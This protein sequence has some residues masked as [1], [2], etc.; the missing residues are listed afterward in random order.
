MNPP[1]A[2]FSRVPT[3][4]EERYRL[5]TET[6]CWVGRTRRS[7]SPPSMKWRQV[8][9]KGPP[10]AQ[11]RV[12]FKSHK[13]TKKNVS[14]LTIKRPTSGTSVNCSRTVNKAQPRAQVLIVHARWT[15][16]TSGS[17][18]NYSSLNKQRSQ[19]QT[20]QTFCFFFLFCFDMF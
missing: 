15:K 3:L 8:K 5:Q 18:G 12:R 19:L 7:V 20:L 13:L 10:R 6:H 16:P 4:V 17:S 9:D 2:Q 1:I 11:R 14:L